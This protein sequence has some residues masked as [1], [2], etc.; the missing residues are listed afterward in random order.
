MRSFDKNYARFS[1]QLG[2]LALASAFAIPVWSQDTVSTG[3]SNNSQNAASQNQ[4]SPD[5]SAPL[6]PPA[7]EGF[8]GRVNPFARKKWVKKQ[9]DPINDRLTELDEVNTKNAR[10]IKDVDARAQAGIQRA[11]ASADAANQVRH[12]FGLLQD[13]VERLGQS[14][15]DR[16]ESFW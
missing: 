16:A 7:K 14:T 15:R 3:M 8:W 9:I 1:R 12:P 6:P 10:D 5:I 4:P 2:V 11:Q 13:H